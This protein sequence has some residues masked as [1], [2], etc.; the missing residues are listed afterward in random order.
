MPRSIKPEAYSGL[1]GRSRI[2]RR[3]KKLRLGY[4]EMLGNP[5][6][7]PTLARIRRA[8]ELVVTA[9]LMRQRVIRG[10][11]EPAGLSE[12]ESTADRALRSLGVDRPVVKAAPS[13]AE[14]L[15]SWGS[16][17]ALD[18]PAASSGSR[19]PGSVKASQETAE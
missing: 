1:D 19:S 15:S 9:E 6:D 7:A 2:A 10:E 12:L 14:Y 5:D 11:I 18:A 3:I 16:E 8:A 13:L 4:S 17:K